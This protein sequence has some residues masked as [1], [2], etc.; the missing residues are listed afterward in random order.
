MNIKGSKTESNLMKALM[1]ES[2]ARN[3]YTFYASQATLEGNKDIAELFEKMAMNESMHA[4]VW[5]KMING[6]MKDSTYNLQ[7]AA[8]GELS[9]WKTMYPDF[10]KTAREEGLDGVAAMF[11][12]IAAIEKDH[13]LQFMEAL[14]K[15][16]SSAS[17]FKAEAEK[18]VE[19][20]VKVKV[21]GYRCMFCGATFK[22]RPDVCDVCSS[23]G[24]FENCT[25]EE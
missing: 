22:E 8:G 23:I 5:Y 25:I 24:S 12:K 4:M 15:L 21:P 7:E 13:E 3:K 14:M 9:E 11:E 20:R 17:T 10:A 18:K 16:H 19:Q 2:L 1:G 6:A